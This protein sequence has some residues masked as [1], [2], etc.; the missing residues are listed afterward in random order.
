MP[1]SSGGGDSG[2]F[3][4]KSFWRKKR[5]S[6]EWL[7]RWGRKREGIWTDGSRLDDGRVGAAAVWWEE[8]YP[9][10]LDSKNRGHLPPHSQSSWLV[11]MAVPPRPQQVGLRRRLYSTLQIFDEGEARDRRYTLFADSAAAID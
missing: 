11:W 2:P 5:R 9:T 4:A 3:L 6:C 10:A 8:A 7:K 1:R